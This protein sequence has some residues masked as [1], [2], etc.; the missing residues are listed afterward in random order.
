MYTPSHLI[1]NRTLWLLP[2]R[3]LRPLYEKAIRLL[4]KTLRSLAKDTSAPPKRQAE[5]SYRGRSGRA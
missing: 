3:P 2:L 4:V 5:V 1:G